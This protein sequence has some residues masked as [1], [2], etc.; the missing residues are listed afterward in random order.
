MS[1]LIYENIKSGKYENEFAWPTMSMCAS[2]QHY[3]ELL[4]AYNEETARLYGIFMTDLFEEYGVKDNP[5][6]VKCYSLA[7]NYGHSSGLYEVAYHFDNFVELI[8]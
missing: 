6:A 1:E 7:W 5:K 2:K 3:Y 4:K 8:K